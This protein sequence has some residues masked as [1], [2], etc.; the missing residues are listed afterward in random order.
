MIE[1]SIAAFPD[2]WELTWLRVEVSRTDEFGYYDFQ[3]H[4]ELIM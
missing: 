3:A 2:P 4:V 1:T